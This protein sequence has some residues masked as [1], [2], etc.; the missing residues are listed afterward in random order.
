MQIS[1]SLY[2]LQRNVMLQK[3]LVPFVP[4]KDSGTVASPSQSNAA[5]SG[6]T[7]TADE[8]NTGFMGASLARIKA[9]AAHGYSYNSQAVLAPSDFELVEQTT[10]VNIKDGNF[11]DADGNRLSIEQDKNGNLIGVSY[12]SQGNLVNGNVPAAVDA[13][14]LTRSLESMRDTAMYNDEP[15]QN[16]K[17]ITAANLKAYVK[18]YQDL[19]VPLPGVDVIA[20]AEGILKAVGNPNQSVGQPGTASAA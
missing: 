4:S 6:F 2:S 8:L 7:P 14:N 20:R 17:A 3:Q 11:Y 15:Y 19:N 9:A 16:G 13:F 18:Q 1:G 12:D 5:A 10:G